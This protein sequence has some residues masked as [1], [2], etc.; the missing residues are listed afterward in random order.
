M[1]LIRHLDEYSLVAEDF[2]EPEIEII[3]PDTGHAISKINPGIQVYSTDIIL[4]VSNSIVRKMNMKHNTAADTA[5]HLAFPYH[6]GTG[7]FS[8]F[9][10]G[11]ILLYF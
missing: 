11:E 10:P 4:L 9:L 6:S 2:L 5:R 8:L 3:N 7:V 1:D